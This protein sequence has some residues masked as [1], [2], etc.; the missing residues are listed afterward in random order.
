MD[1]ALMNATVQEF[2]PFE[3]QELR[4]GYALFE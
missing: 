4:T 2:F 1:R 3:L